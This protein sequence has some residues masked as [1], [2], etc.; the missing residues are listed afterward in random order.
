MKS[1]LARNRPV[2]AAYALVLVLAV[3]GEIIAPGFLRISHV[4]QL[5]IEA[6]YPL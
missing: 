3:A 6:T 1:L 5:V 4:D 2:V